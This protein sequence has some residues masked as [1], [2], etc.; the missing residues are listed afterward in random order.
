M[1]RWKCQAGKDAQDDVYDETLGTLSN[2]DETSG[3]NA[4]DDDIVAPEVT[5]G[6]NRLGT[7]GRIYRAP[8]VDQLMPLKY[9]Y[10]QKTNE[11]LDERMLFVIPSAALRPGT[12]MVRGKFTDDMKN[13]RV[14]SRFVAAGVAR[15]VRHDV[16]AGTAALKAFRMIV[17]LAAT[18]DGRHRPR[19]IAFYD[20]VAALA[21][22]SVHSRILVANCVRRTDGLSFWTPG[23]TLI[24]APTLMRLNRWTTADSWQSLV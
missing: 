19:S 11:P 17:S 8:S 24:F 4:T 3:E 13:G 21:H 1:S 16:H 6:L 12:K 23:E 10:R 20:V 5:E 14:K 9:V 15:D 2:L 22:W 18:R 7:L